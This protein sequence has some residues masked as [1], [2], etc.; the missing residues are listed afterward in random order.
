[1]TNGRLI[2]ISHPEVVVS[3]DVPITEWG[4][5]DTGRLR[6]EI[7]ASSATM[8]GVR[9]IWSSTE[10]KALDTAD[11]LAERASCSIRTHEA[12]GENDRS[13]TGFL[14]PDQFEAA[15]DAFFAEPETSFC[16]WETAQAAQSRIVETVRSVVAEHSDGDLAL[17]THGAVGTLLWCHLSG[18][19]ISRRF[20]QPGQG[21]YWSADLR[22][23]HPEHGWRSIG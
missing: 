10:R 9:A 1:M 17:V 5:S 13:A 18:Q 11:I 2:I 12:L 7:F 23:L 19:E 15:A 6:A 3:P 21:H 4:L 8:S 22:T 16:G 20:D 14:P